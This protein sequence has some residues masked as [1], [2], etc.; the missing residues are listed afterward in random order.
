MSFTEVDSGTGKQLN[1]HLAHILPKP[2]SRGNN[3]MQSSMSL[4]VHLGSTL[5]FSTKRTISSN[6]SVSAAIDWIPS[7]SNNTHTAVFS[8]DKDNVTTGTVDYKKF[9]PISLNHFNSTA[10]LDRRAQ[11]QPLLHIAPSAGFNVSSLQIQQ[12][13]KRGMQVC[14]SEVEALRNRGSN[15]SQAMNLSPRQITRP[16][17]FGHYSYTYDLGW[18]QACVLASV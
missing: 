9:S 11:T 18:C 3:A 6:G 2:H 13:I 7:A 10:K 16:Q 17:D 15:S 1:V 14:Q 5:V 4:D 12:G 8:V